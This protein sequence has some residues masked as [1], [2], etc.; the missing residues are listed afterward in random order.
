MH[1]CGGHGPFARPQAAAR[2]TP[3]TEAATGARPVPAA[4]E[5]GRVETRLDDDETARLRDALVAA[6]Y[7]TDGVL[8]LLGPVA[9]G[10]LARHET[11]PARRATTGGSPLETLVRLFLLQLDVPRAHAER[12]LPLDVVG[13]AG[14]VEVDGADVR[15]LVDVRPYDESFYVVAD[16]GAGLDGTVR[17]L[18]PDHVVGVGGASTTLAEITVRP[19]IGRALD[20]G[21]GCGVQGLHLAAHAEHVVATDVLPR[22]LAM[23]ALSAGLSGVTLDLREGSLYEPVAAQHFDLVVSNPPFVVGPVGR[24]AYRDAGMAGDDVCRRLIADAPSHLSEGGWF[25]CLANWVHRRGEDWR[26]RVAQWLPTGCQAWVVQREVQD[27]AEYASLW[28][29]DSGE[30]RGPD[31]VRLY[32]EWL[33]RFDADA[34]EGVGFG[35]VVLRRTGEA[36]PRVCIEEWSHAV[37]QPLGPHVQAWSERARWLSTRPAEALLDARLAVAADVVLE[38]V[39][40]PG[41]EDPEAVVLRQQVGMRRAE[42]VGT[43]VAGIVGACDGQLPVGRLADAVAAILETDVAAVRRKALPELVRLV[44]HGILRPVD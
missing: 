41:A 5:D 9:Q 4:R 33:T 19:Q 20:I 2:G 42:R 6:G 8:E 14:I 15:A 22:A 32:D 35:W 3:C 21:T 40:R 26:E 17:S 18:R 24:Y 16:I 12:A 27:P 34:T 39:G 30:I 29:H 11:V 1:R 31:H 23:A 38:Q 37:E 25:Q 10:A 43:E 28:L 7:T 13:R 44:D 36:D